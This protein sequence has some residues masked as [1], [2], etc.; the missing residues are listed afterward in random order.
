MDFFPVRRSGRS[1]TMRR[2]RRSSRPRRV[3]TH[4]RVL[5]VPAHARKRGLASRAEKLAEALEREAL[6]VFRVARRLENEL[7]PRLASLLACCSML[8]AIPFIAALAAA[9]RDAGFEALRGWSPRFLDCFGIDVRAEDTGAGVTRR[10]RR[11]RLRAA[12][13]DQPARQPRRRPRPLR[14]FR[15][16]VNF[17]FCWSGLGLPAAG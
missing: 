15:A 7:P 12:Q 11:L 9:D 13:P 5:P 8:T 4:E 14:P 2:T 16:V 6:D 3:A 10:P 1:R 17:E